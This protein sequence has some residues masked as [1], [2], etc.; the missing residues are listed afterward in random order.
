MKKPYI[1]G[2]SGTHGTGK[3]STLESLQKENLDWMFLH[4]SARHVARSFKY[5]D[6]LAIRTDVGEGVLIVLLLECFKVLDP[7]YNP[8]IKKESVV[9]IDRSPLDYWAYYLE[10]RDASYEP[11]MQVE[12]LIRN[13]VE[14]YLSF[15]DK[16]VYFPIDTIPLK[17]DDMRP[18]DDIYYGNVD[19][20]LQSSFIE[21]GV[22]SSRIYNLESV[23]LFGRT[24]EIIQLCK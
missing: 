9:V 8:S 18:S 4:E 12:N 11:D 2:L 13:M 3:T 16:I 22:P 5:S 24:R 6:P 19:T 21:F 10:L 15:F 1:I 23:D 20:Q 7:E 17:E 14:H